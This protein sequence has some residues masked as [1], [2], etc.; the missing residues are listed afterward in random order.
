MV[1]MDEVE[2]DGG[3][4]WLQGCWDVEKVGGNLG[5]AHIYFLIFDIMFYLLIFNSK[6][7]IVILHQLN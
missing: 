2:D 5:G 3:G 1:A 6:G 4:G 7:I